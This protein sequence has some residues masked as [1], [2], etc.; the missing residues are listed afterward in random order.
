MAQSIYDGHIKIFIPSVDKFYIESNIVESTGD[1]ANWNRE[2]SENNYSESWVGIPFN[3]LDKHKYTYKEGLEQLKKLEIDLALGG[4][5]KRYRWNENDGDTVSMERLYESMPAMLQRIK[6]LGEGVGKF[7]TIHA[8][9]G[10]NCMISAKKL[11]HRAYTVMQLVDLIESLGYRIAVHAYIDV[12]QPGYYNGA[13]IKSLNVEVVVKAFNE[14]M[15]K[16]LIL[17]CISPWFFRH[18]MFK[19]WCAKFMMNSGFG[20]TYDPSY[21]DDNENIYI[22]Q[23]QCLKE[24]SEYGAIGSLERID[25]IGKRFGF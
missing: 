7:I 8:C 10:E 15:N 19:F 24:N 6:Q 9:I 5:K 14:P 3:Q 17:T 22:R 12:N 18:H 13:L 23:G 20:H 16:G 25:Q 11:L 2:N 1:Q 4:S 21:V